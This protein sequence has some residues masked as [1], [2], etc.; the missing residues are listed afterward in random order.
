M[1]ALFL[2]TTSCWKLWCLLLECTPTEKATP[3][4]KI[5]N[6][7]NTVFAFMTI[8]FKLFLFNMLKDRL[9]VTVVLIQ[10]TNRPFL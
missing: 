7:K 4:T 2:A 10:Y 9:R 3:D 6:P 1:I 5:T 8:C